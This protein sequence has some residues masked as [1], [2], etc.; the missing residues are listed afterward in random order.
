MSDLRDLECL[1]V[2]SSVQ[3]FM[4]ITIAIGED[5]SQPIQFKVS[6]KP[7]VIGPRNY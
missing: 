1:L 7:R 3:A 6:N 4:R 5:Q 2:M